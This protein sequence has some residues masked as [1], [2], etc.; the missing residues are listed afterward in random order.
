MKS[1]L[2]GGL[3]VTSFG[4]QAKALKYKSVHKL[5]KTY[6]TKWVFMRV[7]MAMVLICKGIGKGRWVKEC[8]SWST[9]EFL[10]LS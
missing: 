1:K 2:S 7:F 8:K 9:L 3:S 5:L 6:D 4:D 10:L